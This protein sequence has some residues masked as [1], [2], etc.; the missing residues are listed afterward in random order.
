MD[1]LYTS[2]IGQKI[3]NVFLNYMQTLAVVLRSAAY[4]EFQA[5]Y[6]TVYGSEA[7]HWQSPGSVSTGTLDFVD[8]ASTLIIDTVANPNVLTSAAFDWSDREIFGIY[9]GLG[10]I[11]RVP[12]EA[13]DYLFDAVAPTLFWGYTGLG[14][15][16]GG[17]TQVA[18]GFPPIPAAGASWAVKIAAN[19]WLYLDPVDGLL[20]FY[21]NTGSTIRNPTLWFFA[22]AQIGARP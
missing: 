9:R 4:S 20:K 13:D 18:P 15:Y 11:D 8:G 22:T 21:N 1:P 14:A 19:L 2:S 10:A 3:P 7:R 6:G 17:T 5:T 12:G 16:S